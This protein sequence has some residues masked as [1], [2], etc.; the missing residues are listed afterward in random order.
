MPDIHPTSILQ[1]GF[2]FF[3]SKT[4]LSAVELGLFTELAKRPMNAEQI[5]Q[6]LGLHHRALPVLG[7]R[8]SSKRTYIVS[9]GCRC[10]GQRHQASS[11]G[12]QAR[13]G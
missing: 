7:I 11:C 5:R 13:M 9:S 12:A 4:L 6:A 10:G 2:G 3:G 8:E 1:V